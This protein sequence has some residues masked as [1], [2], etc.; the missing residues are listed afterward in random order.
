MA[1][2]NN[3]IIIAAL[4]IVV[5]SAAAWHNFGPRKPIPLQ[6]GV[7]EIEEAPVVVQAAVLAPIKLTFVGDM[8]FDRYIRTKASQQSYK[9]ILEE[10]L[11]IFE[12]SD[13][14]V[15]NLEAPVTDFDSVSQQTSTTSAQHFTFTTEPAALTAFSSLPFA[16]N[17]GNN[18]IFN[19]GA[20]GIAQTEKYLAA[21]GI[22]FFGQTGQSTPTY[23]ITEI[24]GYRIAL[25]NYNQFVAG[26]AQQTLEDLELVSGITDLQI[27]YAHW[28]IEY[29]L[30]ARPV[31]VTLA[32]QFVDAG[33][34]VIIG[35]HPHV[36]QNSE[37]YQGAPIFYSLGNFV[38]DQYFDAQ[39]RTGLVVSVMIDRENG[40]ITTSE[41]R[42][43]LEL[44]GQTV[45]ATL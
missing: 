32:H 10:T 29:E 24:E 3:R 8:M 36:I 12:D 17:L 13:L 14:V 11:A 40:E 19:F 33:A 5:L 30:V 44:S 20:E 31:V 21:A 9:F 39:V 42:V 4:V 18:H 7:S 22:G 28:G 15:G 27:V 34:D 45:P 37:I 1:S 35:S 25:I 43:R 23:M 38:F 16:A 26:G 41:Q 6:I 2:M